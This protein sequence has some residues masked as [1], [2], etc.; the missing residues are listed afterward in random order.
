M[1]IV[2]NDFMRTGF[3]RRR[4]LSQYIQD[5]TAGRYGKSQNQEAFHKG[6]RI[7][8]YLLVGLCSTDPKV[9]ASSV[10]VD[11]YSQIEDNTK[12]KEACAGSPGPTAKSKILSKL[13]LRCLWK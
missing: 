9:L 12:F 1:K 10:V 13:G 2:G 4:L 11:V 7:H 8:E 6:F 3:G 5:G